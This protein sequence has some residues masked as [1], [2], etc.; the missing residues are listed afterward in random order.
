MVLQ[1]LFLEEL[2][3]TAPSHRVH[4]EHQIEVYPKYVS[5]MEQT[6]NAVS[7]LKSGTDYEAEAIA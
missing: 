5:I 1:T 4:F 3:Y 6:V 7:F 2:S